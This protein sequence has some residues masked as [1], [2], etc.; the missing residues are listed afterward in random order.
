LHDF[1]HDTRARYVAIGRTKLANIIASEGTSENE[2]EN[3][4]NARPADDAMNNGVPETEGSASTPV[5]ETA[6]T[7]CGKGCNTN[8]DYNSSSSSSA[9]RQR[10]YR[11]RARAMKQQQCLAFVGD[12]GQGDELVA[13]GLL[14]DPGS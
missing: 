13:R 12:S 5:D 4:S 1:F 6:P 14:G 3:G 2:D 11:N 8:L 7:A 10:R 9:K